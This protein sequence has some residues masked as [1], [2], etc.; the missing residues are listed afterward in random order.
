M[1]SRIHRQCDN[2]RP[3]KQTAQRALRQLIKLFPQAD[4]AALASAYRLNADLMVESGSFG[5]AE[6]HKRAELNVVRKIL[7][8]QY[9]EVGEHSSIIQLREELRNVT[10]ARQRKRRATS[11]RSTRNFKANKAQSTI[12]DN[13][14]DETDAA[15]ELAHQEDEDD[16]SVQD[17]DEVVHADAD[18]EDDV[19]VED[20]DDIDSEGNHR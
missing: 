1:L 18:D 12:A 2:V 8:Q 16:D 6:K 20:D 19:F 15:E 4:H 10:D 9:G 5:A 7:Q 14:D 11:L 13:D 17:G 3:A